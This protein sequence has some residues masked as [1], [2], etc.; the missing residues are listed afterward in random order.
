MSPRI[1]QGREKITE[2]RI[3][4]STR[5][6][7]YWHSI[8][9]CGN[10]DRRTLMQASFQAFRQYDSRTWYNLRPA[11]DSLTFHQATR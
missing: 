4:R 2:T 6:A 8:V 3:S 11:G 5:Q 10:R 7:A 9:L 1:K